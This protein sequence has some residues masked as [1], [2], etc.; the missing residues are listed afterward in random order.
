MKIG[1]DASRTVT[2][3]KTGVEVYSHEI[4]TRL[5]RHA[6]AQ[7]TH[8]LIFYT[9]EKIADIKEGPHVIER[10]IRL[11]RLWTHARLSAELLLH[12]VDVLFVP[13]HVLPIIHPK[14]SVVTIHDVA[15]R[16]F[17]EAYSNFQYRYLDWS[18]RAACRHAARIIV[19]SNATRR[20]LEALYDCNSKKISVIPH[21]PPGPH[22]P[23]P[24][25]SHGVALRQAHR[26]IAA[27]Q[28]D[29][30]ALF[31]QQFG[32]EPADRFILFV[33]RLE[34][35]KNLVRLIH[36]FAEFSRKFSDWK[37][38]LAGMQG[39]GFQEIVRAVDHCSLWDRVIMPGYIEESEK[40]WLFRHA[41]FFAFPS[42]YEG[43][44]L[45]V[46]EAFGHGTAVLASDT[47]S[48]PEVGGDGALYADPM[49]VRDLAEKM[50]TLANDSALRDRLIANGKRRLRDFSWER[51]A[52]ETWRLL[53]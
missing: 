30:A 19:P 33:G 47:S 42:L 46:L 10:V 44:G 9:P 25:G 5:A 29:S 13:S 14:K 34:T 11:P 50:T 32:L 17:R 45:P 2:G 15:F 48:L 53:T 37:L 7:K 51:A 36:A 3:R 28:R 26:D 21:G 24:H 20:D 39:V 43:F 18:T 4:T 6:L 31:F 1:V 23:E 8:D 49:N 41:V 12:P 16:H 40:A 22:G 38:V 27:A 35:K 52:R